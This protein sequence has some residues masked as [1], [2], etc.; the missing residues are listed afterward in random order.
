MAGVDAAMYLKIL[1]MGV[2]LFAILTVVCSIIMYP[3]NCTGGEVANLINQP[4][5]PLS[6][7]PVALC[8]PCAADSHKLSGEMCVFLCA[9]QDLYGPLARPRR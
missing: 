1:R 2:E 3:V 9:P 7:C 8:A 5:S 6:F 4:V